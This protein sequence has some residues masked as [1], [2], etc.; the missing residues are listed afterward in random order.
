[1]ALECSMKKVFTLVDEK[2]KPARLVE[3]AKNTVNKYVKR[4]RKKKLPE[5]VDFWDFSC[6]CGVSAEEAEPVHFKGLF[7]KIDKIVEAGVESFYVEVVAVEGT[8]TK[9]PT[10]PT[11]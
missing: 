1:M 5:G 10:E 3:A 7:G 2:V 9:K 8:R 11:E 6:K 4:E